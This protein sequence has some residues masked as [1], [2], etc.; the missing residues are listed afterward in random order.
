MFYEIGQVCVKES[1]MS[2]MHCMFIHKATK[3]YDDPYEKYLSFSIRHDVTFVH[4]TEFC[5]CTF[6][7]CLGLKRPFRVQ[8]VL[9]PKC[10]RMGFVN[11]QS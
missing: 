1:C 3:V 9:F 8:R 6:L 5:C 11:V 7:W 4:I 2:K 10:K